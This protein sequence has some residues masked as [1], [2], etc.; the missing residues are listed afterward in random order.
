MRH[1]NHEN[2]DSVTLANMIDRE[3]FHGV[4]TVR[5]PDPLDFNL[6]WAHELNKAKKSVNP[7]GLFVDRKYQ[8][9]AQ[10]AIKSNMRNARR[11]RH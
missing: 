1:A 11:V 10:N 2:I 5:N 4:N 9:Q 8:R 3:L 7:I 6:L